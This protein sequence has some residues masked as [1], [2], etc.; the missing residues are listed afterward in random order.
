[1]YG[2]FRRR[3]SHRIKIIINFR[4]KYNNI[5]VVKLYDIVICKHCSARVYYN[6][7]LLPVGKLIT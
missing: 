3:F 7:A 1:M 5:V 4:N 6:I 2:Q